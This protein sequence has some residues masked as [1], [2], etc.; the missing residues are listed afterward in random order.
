MKVNK[1]RKRT[2]KVKKE[3]KTDVTRETIYVH[4]SNRV[5]NPIIYVQCYTVHTPVEL[6]KP[7]FLTVRVQ[8]GGFLQ[9]AHSKRSRLYIRNQPLLSLLLLLLPYARIALFMHPYF[10]QCSLIY[11][12]ALVSAKMK[13]IMDMDTKYA[14]TYSCALM[15]IKYIWIHIYE[16]K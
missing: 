15:H 3:K 4:R 2:N 9:S 6:S 13:R 12:I 10:I 7:A 1:I 16:N 11:V 14:N 5:K 8:F